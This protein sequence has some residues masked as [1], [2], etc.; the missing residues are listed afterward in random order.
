MHKRYHSNNAVKTNSGALPGF[1][2]NSRKQIGLSD[3]D[4]LEIIKQAN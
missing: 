3:P 2:T 4:M 1:S